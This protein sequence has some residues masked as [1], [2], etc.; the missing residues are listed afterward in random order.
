MSKIKIEKGI[1]DDIPRKK[2]TPINT[3][4]IEING[5]IGIKLH[6]L[7]KGYSINYIKNGKRN[8]IK[9]SILINL[10]NKDMSLPTC[11]HTSHIGRFNIFY[12]STSRNNK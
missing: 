7:G 9:K 3:S 6:C 10:Q 1:K 8:K 12:S 11:K 4:R 5:E 2:P